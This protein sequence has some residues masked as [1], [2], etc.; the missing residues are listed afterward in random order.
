MFSSI[1]S[2][3]SSFMPGGGDSADQDT[4][5]T[6]DTVGEAEWKDGILSI[7][8]NPESSAFT[9]SDKAGFIG[10]RT[11]DLKELCCERKK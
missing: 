5:P 2:Y 11:R 10:V 1:I 6:P 7:C 3:A 4:W 8:F 9:V